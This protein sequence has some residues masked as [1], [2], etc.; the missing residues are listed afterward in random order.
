MLTG[1]KQIENPVNKNVN[2][3]LCGKTTTLYGISKVSGSFLEFGILISLKSC[4]LVGGLDLTQ[5]EAPVYDSHPIKRRD[6]FARKL[7]QIIGWSMFSSHDAMKIMEADWEH[8]SNIS[9]IGN[10]SILFFVDLIWY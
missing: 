2:G 7:K 6:P 4:Y 3:L 10:D 5:G 8:I 9:M 1:C